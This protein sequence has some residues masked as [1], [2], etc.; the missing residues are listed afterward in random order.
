MSASPN[1]I[2]LAASDVQK[3]L[4][5][6]MHLGSKNC[7]H[8]MKK[9]IF[10]RRDDG[11][12]IMNLQK[13][14]EKIQ[15]AA[16]ILV[17]IENPADICV[18]SG[19]QYGQRACLKF[20]GHVGSSPIAGRFTPGTFTNQIQKAFMEPRVLVVTDPRTDSQAV[21]ESAYVSIPVIAL[22]D[23]DSPLE[24]VDVAI[25]CNNKSKHS[26]GL[27]YWLLAREVLRLRG[28]ISRHTEWDVMADLYFFRD[29]DEVAEEEA[30][31]KR[32]ATETEVPQYASWDEPNAEVLPSGA[33]DMAPAA[34]GQDWSGAGDASW[35]EGAKTVVPGGAVPSYQH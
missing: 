15:A 20:C 17:T 8:Q 34:V 2:S 10:K 24:H 7:H 16:R 32:M 12:F 31:A 22:C 28:T 9:Y 11:V 3:M 18:I 21:S 19:R 6:Q 26:I 27:V 29:A 5:A 1:P 33:Y 25:P 4:A 14:W 35:N 13:T 30:E 23:S